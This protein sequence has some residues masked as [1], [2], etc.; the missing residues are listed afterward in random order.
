MIP[1]SEFA[2]KVIELGYDFHGFGD[3]GHYDAPDLYVYM[4]E[5]IEAFSGYLRDF[6]PKIPGLEEFMNEERVAGIVAEVRDNLSEDPPNMAGVLDIAEQLN[7]AEEVQ[8]EMMG[9]MKRYMDDLLK[10]IL[11]DMGYPKDQIEQ[12]AAS[13]AYALGSLSDAEYMKAVG[14][15]FG[16]QNDNGALDQFL[17]TSYEFEGRFDYVGS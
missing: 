3:E 7:L 12:A 17:N 8:A 13:M 15:A 11:N 2:K 9:A 1:I 5:I 16:G 14:G 6:L 10:R 4:P